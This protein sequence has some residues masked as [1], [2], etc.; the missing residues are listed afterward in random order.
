MANPDNL[1]ETLSPPNT[2]SPM[3]FRSRRLNVLLS[4][5]ACEPGRGS[6]PEVGWQWSLQMAR[7]H[8]VT[9]LTRS[10]NRDV[11][12]K[13]LAA[14]PNGTPV[15]EFVYFDLPEPVIRIKKRF[16]LHKTYYIMW[17]REARRV[18][19]SLVKQR[20]FDI[21]HHVTFATY[22]STT[23]IWGFDV[24]SIWGPV[25]GIESVPLGLLPWSHPTSLAL[26]I[27]RNIDNLIEMTVLGVLRRRGLQSSMVISTTREM[28]ETFTQLGIRSRLM[29]TVG[30]HTGNLPPAKTT[31][32]NAPLKLLYV[33]ALLS[34]KGID[35]M[36]EALAGTDTGATLTIVGDG[37][38][39]R[40]LQR[41]AEKLGLQQRVRFVGK[42]PRN[43][44]LD[45]YQ[46]HDLFCFP[47]LHDTGGFA[48]LEAM[49]NSLPIVCLNVGG[50]RIAVGE[51]AGIRVPVGSRASVIHG[52][53]QALLVY[54]RD[55]DRLESDGKS[56]RETLVRE[57]DWNNKGEAMNRLYRDLLDGVPIEKTFPET[58][59]AH[60]VD[61]HSA[62]AAWASRLLT[63]HH[64]KPHPNP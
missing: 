57:F 13:G 63:P 64:A 26:E 2:L 9:V 44:V 24:P 39:R 23:A 51:T 62:L 55:R 19:E 11:I 29:P 56:G 31:N 35:L 59:T 40:H 6:E 50:P 5:Y 49:S 16:G 28:Q 45:I 37:P 22:R 61:Y 46:S 58:E 42:L 43:Q 8:K 21:L 12:E 30:M 60:G 17:Q 53:R 54:D 10:N 33:G 48:V 25:G 36:L 41:L 27:L 32:R 4:A 52:L 7:F 15:P 47:S 18:V 1:R 38:Y 14:L 3:D 20:I 34:L